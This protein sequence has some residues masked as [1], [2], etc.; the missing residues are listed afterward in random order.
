MKAILMEWDTLPLLSPPVRDA[1]DN[2]NGQGYYAVRGHC[3]YVGEEEVTWYEAQ[4]R[5]LARSGD[6]AVLADREL[7]EEMHIFMDNM[8]PYAKKVW[9]GLK[10]GGYYW[11]SGK[12]IVVNL[13]HHLLISSSD[14]SLIFSNSHQGHNLIS[15]YLYKIILGG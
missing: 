8:F 4:E 1:D 10:K 5:C 12:R 7:R 6:L 3:Y 15:Y 13:N 11:A 14:I 9:I 2:C